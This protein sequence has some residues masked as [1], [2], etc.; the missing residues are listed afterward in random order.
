MKNQKNI[1]LLL[2]SLSFYFALTSCDNSN[3]NNEIKKIAVA[4]IEVQNYYDLSSEEFDKWKV[5]HQ[6]FMS[7]IFYP[8]LIIHKI[9]QDC[10][11]IGSIFID[12]VFTFDNNGRVKKMVLKSETIDCE[13]LDCSAIGKEVKELM[14]KQFLIYFQDMKFPFSFSKKVIM[15]QI[16]QPMKC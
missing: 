7:D 12:V 6:K 10:I 9:N 5:I 3:K 2:I 8:F 15:F 11:N 16:G 13:K 14:K 1:I 4:H